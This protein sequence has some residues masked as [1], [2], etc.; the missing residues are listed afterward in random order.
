MYRLLI[1]R[2]DFDVIR[3]FFLFKIILSILLNYDDQVCPLF[4]N[5]KYVILPREH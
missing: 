1:K 3:A 4:L 2:V 5:G